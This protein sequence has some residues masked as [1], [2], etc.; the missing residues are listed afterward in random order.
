VR[1]L[2][3]RRRA[4]RAE[5]AALAVDAEA[6][7]GDVV[8]AY[9]RAS[10][11]EGFPVLAAYHARRSVA[12]ERTLRALGRAWKLYGAAQRVAGAEAA[13]VRRMFFTGPVRALGLRAS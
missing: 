3:A 5:G 4:G 9:A 2:T 10:V 1:L 13:L 11:A 8:R 6:S 7:V 12:E